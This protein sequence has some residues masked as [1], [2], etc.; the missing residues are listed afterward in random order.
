MGMFYRL[1]RQHPPRKRTC[2]ASVLVVCSGLGLETYNRATAS[3]TG[4]LNDSMTFYGGIALML[5]ATGLAS[6]FLFGRKPKLFGIMSA[7]S[8][9]VYFALAI[10]SRHHPLEPLSPG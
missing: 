6:G 4:Y 8:V 3:W 7:V 10:Y 2:I 9:F 1:V 5:V